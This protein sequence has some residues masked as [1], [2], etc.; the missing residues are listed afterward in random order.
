MPRGIPPLRRARR[1]LTTTAWLAVIGLIGVPALE[2]PGA[3]AAD[4]DA[5]A[6]MRWADTNDGLTVRGISGLQIHPKEADTLFAHVAGLGPAKS[7]DGGK[8]W[9]GLLQGSDYKMASLDPQR[10][11]MTL[12]PRAPDIVFL[13]INGD[14]YR[15]ADGGKAF[16]KMR[17]GALT[18]YSWDKLEIARLVW[19]VHV[20]DK[21]SALLLAGTRSDGR[22]HG[23][24]FESQDGGKSWKLIAGSTE[25]TSGLGH[26]AFWIR[27]DPKTEKNL[28]VAGKTAVWYSDDRG[29]TFR[30]NQPNVKGVRT[31]DVR[32]LSRYVSSSRDLYL[33]DARGIWH[34]KDGGKKWGGKPLRNGDAQFVAIDPM[35]RKHVFAIFADEGI[36]MQ[37]A[38]KGKWTPMGTP[39]PSGSGADNSGPGSYQDADVRALAFHPREKGVIYATS[40]VTGLHVSRDGGKLFKPVEIDE[41]Q[42]PAVTASLR[43]VGIHAGGGASTHLAVSREGVVFRSESGVTWDRVGRLGMSPRGLLAETKSPRTWY[44]WGTKLKR[45]DDNGETWETIWSDP[46]GEDYVA[47]FKQCPNGSRHVLLGRS[48]KILRWGPFGPKNAMA[49]GAA[50]TPGRALTQGRAV[51]TSFALDPENIDHVV[52]CTR[53]V[54]DRWTP[55]DKAGGVFES[56]DGGATWAFLDG[57]HTGKAVD[58]G[59]W[60]HGR[61]VAF[62][63]ASKLLLYGAD[64]HGVHARHYVK[65]KSKEAKAAWTEWVDVTPPESLT[66]LGASSISALAKHVDD[67]N[68]EYV[69]QLRAANNAT[70]IVQIDSATLRAMWEA[71]HKAATEKKKDKKKDEEGEP[72]PPPSWSVRKDPGAVLS[73]MALDPTTPGRM[74]ATDAMGQS[75]VFLFQIPAAA[76]KEAAAEPEKDESEKE[77]DDKG[78]PEKKGEDQ[79]TDPKTDDKPAPKKDSDKPDEKPAKVAATSRR[80][81][82]GGPGRPGPSSLPCPTGGAPRSRGRAPAARRLRPTFQ[83]GTSRVTAHLAVDLHGH[84]HGVRNERGR[85]VFWPGAQHTPSPGSRSAPTARR[86]CAARTDSAS[87]GTPAPISSGSASRSCIALHS[88]ISLLI[89][90]L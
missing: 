62:D 14:L 65:P 67:K 64:W 89:A 75:G 48:G 11:R 36:L 16:E 81:P 7:T 25:P 71:A 77:Q 55:A 12:D 56:W 80:T 43:A 30:L 49:W 79:P 86:R 26:D 70:A 20:D 17:A 8:S 6:Q 23:G 22:H 50:K 3:M 78:A 63:T 61:F 19:E 32:G 41:K 21:K 24:L 87:P 34:S 84:R 13:A 40:P 90:V 51:A 57:L 45:S 76:K 44:A 60:N 1:F 68:S 39:A 9:S 4:S 27:R 35:S 28:T 10:V 15:S 73:S 5:T 53:S 82:P 74:V 72:A 2:V 59:Y 42:W 52:V 37:S 69:M 58:D 33:A 88:T 47:D 85:I 29:R 46:L 18:S 66:S 54:N 38:R 83:V 31:L